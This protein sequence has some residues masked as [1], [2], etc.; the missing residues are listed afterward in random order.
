MTGHA[1]PHGSPEVGVAFADWL[2][3]VLGS[4]EPLS[5][6]RMATFSDGG[7]P[8]AAGLYVSEA[9]PAVWN[10]PPFTNS[11]M[12][13]F[14]VAAADLVDDSAETVTL[15]VCGDIAAGS[16][17][18]WLPGKAVRIMTGAEIPEGAD[19]IVPVEFTDHP[20]GFGPLPDTVLLPSNWPADRHVR[21]RGS[22]VAAGQ[23]IVGP[24]TL[25]DGSALS[26]LASVGVFSI[27]VRPAPKVAV[28]VTGDE[29]L[30]VEQ[31]SMAGGVT[32]PGHI[33]NSNS[34]LVAETLE[35]FGADVI[36][37]MTCGDTPE[38]LDAA[39]V[40]AHTAGADLVVSTGGASVGAHDVARKLFGDLGVRFSMVGMQPG[41]PQGFGVVEGTAICALP[42]NPGAV[43]V[44]L[45]AIVRPLVARMCG[46]PVPSDVMMT[47]AA[48]WN[49]RE[50]SRQFIPVHIDGGQISPVIQGGVASHR[51]RSL[52]EA[53][54][55]AVVA[56]PVSAV[57]P[58][59]E[60]PVI[61]LRNR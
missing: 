13:G 26:A 31:L 47:V 28:I 12:D 23:Q 5:P 29:L 45:Y 6:V 52:A 14:A 36:L 33:I 19:T 32:P 7:R 46:A 56:E 3:H 58:G 54:G 17:G 24:G 27:S 59:D 50:G 25:L 30:T 9:T 57:E 61:V 49:G 37:E 40:R 22:D 11:A 51:V 55:L 10:A 38:E 35:S 44:S 15:E 20:V 8:Q 1:D 43:R 4:V 42:G 41:R 2:D 60:L 34:V 16:T 39:L 48:G 18:E 21:T 53:D